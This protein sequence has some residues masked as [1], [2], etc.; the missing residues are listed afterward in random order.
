MESFEHT[1]GD[2]SIKCE[3]FPLLW[4]NLL[5]EDENVILLPEYDFSIVQDFFEILLKGKS[6]FESLHDLEQF[7]GLAKD[8]FKATIIK[9]KRTQKNTQKYTSTFTVEKR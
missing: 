4:R 3:I 7:E 5:N 8:I 9:L 6:Y 2:K 1:L